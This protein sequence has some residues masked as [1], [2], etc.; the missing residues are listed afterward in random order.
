MRE[1]YCSCLACLCV[2]VCVSVCSRSSCFSVR[3]NQ[4]TTILTGLSK[5]L[6]HTQR[7]SRAFTVFTPRAFC[8]VLQYVVRVYRARNQTWCGSVTVGSQWVCVMVVTVTVGW[9]RVGILLPVLQN[10]FMEVISITHHLSL[11]CPTGSAQ[12]PRVPTPSFLV[13]SAN[14]TEPIVLAYC[15]TA[16]VLCWPQHF[17]AQGQRSLLSPWGCSVPSPLLPPPAGLVRCKAHHH[18]PLRVHQVASGETATLT[19]EISVTRDSEGSFR[20]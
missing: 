12:A 2:C 1:G 20:T 7:F 16:S 14:E 17:T 10:V 9:W 8:N 5:E 19:L 18:P 13:G 15:D 11:L 6:I 4:Q 3:W